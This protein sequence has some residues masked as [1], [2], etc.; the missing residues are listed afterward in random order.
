MRSLAGNASRRHGAVM[1][2]LAVSLALL[3]AAPV[4]A[5]PAPAPSVFADEP[6]ARM[7]ALP[8]LRER[9][10]IE[11]AQL[12]ERLDTLV[13]ALM[14]R[15]GVDMWILVAREYLED[16]VL[17]TMLDARSFAA[18]RRTILV[19]HDPGPGRP[20]ERLTVSRYGLADLFA[21]AWNPDDQPDQWARLAQ[22]VRE[23]DPKRIA[24]NVS[25]DSAFADGLTKSQHDE[26]V[27]ALPAPW[28]DR[29][30]PA[31]DLAIDWL[32]ARTPAELARY[33]EVMRTAHA[34]LAEA[35]SAR[36]ITPGRTTAADVQ[37]WLR[38]RTAAL[39]LA[40]WFHPS[41]AIFRAGATGELT[42]D[43]II[44]PGDMLWSDFGIIHLGL[45]TD[46]QQLAY[47]LKPG[48]R[49]APAGLRA[50][51]AAANAAQDALNTSFATGRSGNDVLVAAR[52]RAAAAGLDATI[53]SHPLGT[54]GHGAGPAIGFW[55]D[56]VPGPLGAGAILP[57]TAW[58]I[59]LANARAV[60]EWGGQRVSFRLEENAW[61]DGARVR[62]ING[63]QRR[64]HL[65]PGSPDP[66]GAPPL[67]G[68]QGSD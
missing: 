16:P 11:D 40:V 61:F 27:A 48:E 37:W 28:R 23:R 66:V 18:R 34:I 2:L 10:A 14:R 1:R 52:A 39:G 20:V 4:A 12:R 26:L 63:R 35:L 44:Q 19:F 65:I 51:L 24:I 22:I 53:Y 29:L 55:D 32:Q 41:I 68:S 17:E 13:P 5:Q 57:M 9:A 54:H 25:A 43:A 58:S 30:I 50:G 62:W 15:H 56:Q 49:D 45:A 8:P 6:D 60:P 36:V 59:E 64:F 46:T 67:R 38:E 31:G 33:P 3:A 42:G 47:V 7:P 21:S